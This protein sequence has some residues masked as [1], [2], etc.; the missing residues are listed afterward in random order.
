M[1][2]I[3]KV[4]SLTNR[5][6]QWKTVSSFRSTWPKLLSNGTRPA[7]Q[8][9]SQP[10]RSW[11]TRG[12]FG[13]LVPTSAKRETSRRPSCWTGLSTPP[14]APASCA[15]AS[16][17]SVS[18][19]ATVRGIHLV[20]CNYTI[21]SKDIVLKRKMYV[22]ECAHNDLCVS[23]IN[24]P[25]SYLCT[26]P[27]GS[28]GNAT[29]LDGCHK[30]DKFTVPLKAVTGVSRS[31]LLVILV[32]FSVHLSVQKR[33]T[34]RAKQRFFEQNGGLLLRQK[35]GSLASS[36]VARGGRP[37]ATSTRRRSLAEE[38]TALSTGASSP[39]VEPLPSRSPAQ[40][41]LQGNPDTLAVADQPQNA[42]KGCCLEVEVPMLIYEYVSNGQR[43]PPPLHPPRRRQE[44]GA[45]AAG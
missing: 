40:G 31:V 21:G 19:R 28:S 26:C 23:S 4:S 11:W 10:K 43:Q 25:G 3:H 1:Y 30:K 8:F 13:S 32:C 17:A 2:V 33:G 39:T 36:G 29:V 41:V 22:E 44:Q 38:A 45:N 6:S 5:G 16:R 37:P 35:L 18:T 12:G 34:L 14:G 42:V 27:R 9:E 7:H 15:T 24:T 20:T